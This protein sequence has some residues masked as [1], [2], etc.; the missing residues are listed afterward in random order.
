M[1]KREVMLMRIRNI[2]N[3]LIWIHRELGYKDSK[4]NEHL[5][6]YLNSI[7]DKIAE[8]KGYIK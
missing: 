5:N 2:I 6:Y 3:D 1:G 4:A 8:L 7:E